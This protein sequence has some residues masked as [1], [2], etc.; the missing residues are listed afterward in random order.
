MIFRWLYL[1]VTHMNCLDGRNLLV[2]CSISRLPMLFITGQAAIR[3]TSWW[4]QRRELET[5]LLCICVCLCVCAC[6]PALC[7]GVH[8]VCV[9]EIRQDEI[10]AQKR[11][12]CPLSCCTERIHHMQ[13]YCMYVHV[14][15]RAYP[16]L[17]WAKY[18]CNSFAFA[19]I[20]SWAELKDL[21]LFPCTQK[22]QFFRILF[23]NL[24]KSL[25]VS[26]SPA[27]I[28]P[29]HSCGIA[30]YWLNSVITTKVGLRLPT[31]KHH[32]KTCGFIT[33]QLPQVF[34]GNTQM[35]GW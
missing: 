25:P 1:P 18:K 14:H 5:P 29:P 2:S 24:S 32:T 27:M 12:S 10:S 35:T 34:W 30:R 11:L 28:Q 17:H 13:I 22:A 20:F 26:A 16:Y 15:A 33:K 6:I 4:D 8:T 19:P 23:T 31:M 9:T 7:V 21:S 3:D